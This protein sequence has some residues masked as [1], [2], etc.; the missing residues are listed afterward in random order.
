[1]NHKYRTYGIT[2]KMFPQTLLYST[3]KYV[4]HPVI[5]IMEKNMNKN[6]A[7]AQLLSPV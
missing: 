3:G 5:N 1:M 4:Q 7:Y 6:C 2:M